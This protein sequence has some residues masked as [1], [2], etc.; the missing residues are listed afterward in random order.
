MF[1]TFQK[2]LHG[3]GRSPTAVR[4]VEGVSSESHIL[5]SILR[6]YNTRLEVKYGHFDYKLLLDQKCR[7]SF[8][9]IQLENN[10]F[11]CRLTPSE[12]Q[13]LNSD[14]QNNL[15]TSSLCLT[16]TGIGWVECVAT[17]LNRSCWALLC[18][19]PAET[20]TWW[21]RN[22]SSLVRGHTHVLTFFSVCWTLD[23]QGHFLSLQ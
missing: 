3:Y 17:T 1:Q 19:G 11:V 15:V 18:R 2:C 23:L 4:L 9:Y 20:S 22:S 5:L 13:M 8:P 12:N 6:L 7:S 10:S 14:G 21:R 16:L